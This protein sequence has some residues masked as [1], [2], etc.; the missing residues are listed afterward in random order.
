MS[1]DDRYG[2]HLRISAGAAPAQ[3]IRGVELLA[4]AWD[5]M[6]AQGDRSGEAISLPV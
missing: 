4:R 2:G 5:Q 6:A 3:I 1:P